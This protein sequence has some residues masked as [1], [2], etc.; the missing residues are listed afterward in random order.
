LKFYRKSRRVKV[1]RTL[2][3]GSKGNDVRKLQKRLKELGFNPG[4]IDGE[5]GP[6]TEAAVIAL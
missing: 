3:E 1:M 2:R 5:F 4:L 6:A